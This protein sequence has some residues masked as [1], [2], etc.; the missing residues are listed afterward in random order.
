MGGIFTIGYGNREFGVFVALL[1]QYNIG[2][3]CDVRSTPYSLRYEGF[4]REPLS[5]ELDRYSIKYL[6]LGAQL[7]ARPADSQMY[8][9]GRVSY[10]AMT[11]SAAFGAGIERLRAGLKA[12]R[13][14]IMCAE[15]D[16]FDC[17]RAILIGRNLAREGV[18]V[19]HIGADAKLAQQEDIEKRLL[20]KYKLV[21][22]SFF[23]PPSDKE[24]LA[25]AYRRRGT[26]LAYDIAA[27]SRA[28]TPS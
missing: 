27:A 18:L 8:V 9:D 16:P 4:N 21:Q 23:E 14:A 22:R 24:I 2:V 12:H 26:E 15:K 17:H 1:E 7:G 13:I 20:A 3:V 5:R 11:Q 25:E 28:H 19:Q 6:Y 10:E